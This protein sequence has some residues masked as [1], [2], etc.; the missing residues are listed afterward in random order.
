MVKTVTKRFRG[1]VIENSNACALPMLMTLLTAGNLASGIT[2][3]MCAAHGILGIG[4]LWCFC[5]VL[6]SL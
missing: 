4:A 6:R 1:M 3:I 2:A 5:Y